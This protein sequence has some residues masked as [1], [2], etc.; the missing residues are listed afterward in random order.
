MELDGECGVPDVIQKTL[1]DPL[2]YNIDRL[3]HI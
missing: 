2:L 3:M 1:I